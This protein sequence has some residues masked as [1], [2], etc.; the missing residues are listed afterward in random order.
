M[1]RES[2]A[3][4][5]GSLMLLFAGA[6]PAAPPKAAPAPRPSAMPRPPGPIMPAARPRPPGAPQYSQNFFVGNHWHAHC[7]PHT[8]VYWNPGY[9]GWPYGYYYS[10]PYWYGWPY[11]YTYMYP[12]PATDGF[13]YLWPN[14]LGGYPSYYPVTP[15]SAPPG[16]FGPPYA[17]PPGMMPAMPTKP[18]PIPTPE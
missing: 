4:L 5:T 10:R 12:Y 16:W 14:G 3:L 9:W 18:E 2:L 13:V 1:T 15:W 17:A 11:P 8:F 6:L 7:H